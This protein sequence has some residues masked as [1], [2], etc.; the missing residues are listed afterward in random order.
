MRWSLCPRVAAIFVISG[1]AI[2]I[3]TLSACCPGLADGVQGPGSPAGLPP[4]SPP[5]SASAYIPPNPLPNLPNQIS[6]AAINQPQGPRAEMPTT[7]ATSQPEPASP[8][9]YLQQQNAFLMQQTALQRQQL[10]LLRDQSRQQTMQLQG[11][12]QEMQR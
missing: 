12:R 3:E 10:E 8:Y 1:T 5:P 4:P 7:A 2:L 6:Q 9:A 11:I